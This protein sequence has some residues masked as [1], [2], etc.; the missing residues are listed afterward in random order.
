MLKSKHLSARTGTVNVGELNPKQEIAA[1]CIAAG[2]TQEEAAAEAACGTR[3]IKTWVSDLPAFTRR[4]SELRAEMTSRA[5]G[6]LLEN[7]FSAA[8]TLGYLCR[9]GKSEMIRLSAARAI[10]ELSPKLHESTE[11]QTRLA[12]LENPQRERRA[13]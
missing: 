13:G 12:A 7:M 2:K 5:L 3:T 8:D 6:K 11:M 10:L 9:K 4:I 1:L